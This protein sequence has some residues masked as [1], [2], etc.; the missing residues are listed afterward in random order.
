MVRG[1]ESERETLRE[2][3]VKICRER[4]EQ[5]GSEREGARERDR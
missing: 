2:R 1:D 3:D 4:Y 5:R